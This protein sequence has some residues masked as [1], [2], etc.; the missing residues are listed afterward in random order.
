[1][2]KEYINISLRLGY[3]FNMIDAYMGPNPMITISISGFSA[4]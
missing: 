1:M 2:S 4:E 3:H